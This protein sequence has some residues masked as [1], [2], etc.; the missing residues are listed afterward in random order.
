MGNIFPHSL[1]RAACAAF[2]LSCVHRSIF[3]FL[4]LKCALA[5]LSKR[6]IRI[7]VVST[8]TIDIPDEPKEGVSIKVSFEPFFLH[9][10]PSQDVPV[11]SILAG[12]Q[13]HPPNLVF[14][15]VLSRV[16]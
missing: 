12:Y 13:V 10:P 15:K 6:I 1:M 14:L 5:T 16:V 4:F 2:T 8:Y 3:P 11:K 9:P 7:F